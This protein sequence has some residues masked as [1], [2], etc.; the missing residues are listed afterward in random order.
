MSLRARIFLG[1]VVLVILTIVTLGAPLIIIVRDHALDEI[2]SALKG[3]AYRTA[4]LLVMALEKSDRASIANI[5]SSAAHQSLSRI[6]VTDAEGNLLFD[7]DNP[8]RPAEDFSNR[9]EIQAAIAGFDTTEIRRSET[10]GTE[11]L[12]VAVPAAR[13]GRI[14]GAVRLS[15]EIANV[16]AEQLKIT[17]SILLL[18]ALLAAVG[19]WIASIV[20]RSIGASVAEI[21]RA[22][23]RIGHGDYS[24]RAAEGGPPEIRSLARSL[25]NSAARVEAAIATE[26][27]FVGNAAHQLKTP[28]TAIGIRLDSIAKTAELDEES[29]GNLLEARQEVGDLA[30]LIDQLLALA[31][32]SGDKPLVDQPV[33]VRPALKAVA[34]E[35]QERLARVGIDLSIEIAP[36]LPRISLAADLLAE[37]CDNLLDNVASY[38]AGSD[39]AEFLAFSNGDELIVRVAD[40]GPGIDERVRETV[41]DRFTRGSSRMPGA[42]LGMALVRQ[43]AEAAGGRVEL[44][45][46]EKGTTVTIRIPA[47]AR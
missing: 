11:I 2:E 13:E 29:L 27:T 5:A 25:N 9:P 36:D 19:A 12:V 6:T 37:A 32:T 21:A 7:S 43:V 4:S 34:L 45:T 31:R 35:W 46:S 15:R 18:L 20:S 30:R 23:S 33:D 16:R 41:F 40:E 26:K 47:V 24:A 22:A 42:G 1:L 28:L 10:L 39:A 3:D 17:A 14:A 38:C 44:E 8:S